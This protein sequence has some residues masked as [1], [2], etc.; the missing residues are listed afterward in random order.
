MPCAVSSESPF[1]PRESRDGFQ[2]G[3][4]PGTPREF[5]PPK[6]IGNRVHCNENVKVARPN[7]TGED[8]NVDKAESHSSGSKDCHRLRGSFG[9]LGCYASSRAAAGPSERCGLLRI[10][11]SEEHTS[12]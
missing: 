10:S 4:T 3:A 11:R 6:P 7:R 12:E 5:A 9:D 8:C 2:D 1:I